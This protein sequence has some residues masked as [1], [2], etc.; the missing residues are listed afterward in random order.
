MQVIRRE[1]RAKVCAVAPDRPVFHQAVLQ[2]DL[3]AGLDVVARKHSLAVRADRLRRDRR[4][5]LVRRNGHPDQDREPENQDED[6][7]LPPPRRQ[8]VLSH[9][10]ALLLCGAP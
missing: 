6:D 7:G 5:V 9:I 1:V 4:R 2:K 3:L 8:G 10:E